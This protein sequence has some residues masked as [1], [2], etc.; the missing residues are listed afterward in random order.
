M[1]CCGKDVELDLSGTLSHASVN[2]FH[3][4]LKRERLLAILGRRCISYKERGEKKFEPV[5]LFSTKN[6]SVSQCMGESISHSA[7]FR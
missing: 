6:Y 4:I 1:F 2:G 3:C 5:E 7:V